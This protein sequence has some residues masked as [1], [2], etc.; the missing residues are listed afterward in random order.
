MA[1]QLFGFHEHPNDYAVTKIDVPLNECKFLLDFARPLRRIRWFGVFN[2]WVGP[3][4]A[5]EVPVVHLT[6]QSGAFVI[7]VRRSDPYFFDLPRLWKEHSSAKRSLSLP[8]VGVLQ[9]A[10]DFGR[11]FADDCARES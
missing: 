11:H 6:E 5:W 7:G 3:T 10:A 8:P 2:S 1:L 4:L 9:I